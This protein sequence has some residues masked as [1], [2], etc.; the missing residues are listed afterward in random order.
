[1]QG[2][3]PQGLFRR[4]P[5]RTPLKDFLKKVLENPKNFE[6]NGC[7]F[8]HIGF[9]YTFSLLTAPANF[10]FRAPRVCFAG[11]CP[12]PRSENFLKKVFRDLSKTLNAMLHLYPNR[13]RVMPFSTQPSPSRQAVPPLPTG[14]AFIISISFVGSPLGRAGAVRRLRGSPLPQILP[15]APRATACS[16]WQDSIATRPKDTI[17]KKQNEKTKGVIQGVK[18]SDKLKF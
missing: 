11:R 5:P 13:D 1:L 12:A 18:I 17:S 8:V 3:A 14:E 16:V 4:A 7:L 15:F 6:R 9:G 10:P 2:S